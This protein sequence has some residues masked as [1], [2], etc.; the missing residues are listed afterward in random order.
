MRHRSRAGPL[1]W[2][3]FAPAPRRR[4]QPLTH[5][6]GRVPA[7]PDARHGGGTEGRPHP[8]FRGLLSGQRRPHGHWRAT[9]V[10]AAAAAGPASRARL[11]A[12]DARKFDRQIRPTASRSHSSTLVRV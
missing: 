11:L 4:L 7:T 12:V 8:E 5:R 2:G 9:A 6:A 3:H 1:P 10:A